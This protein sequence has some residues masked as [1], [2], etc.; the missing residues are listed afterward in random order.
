MNK[1]IL[2]VLA[3]GFL[4]AVLVALMVQMSLSGNKKQ[5]VAAAKPEAKAMIVVAAKDLKSGD[6]LDAQNMKWQEWP[7][8]GVFPGAYVQ[9]KKDQSVTD[10][11]T[12]RAKGD[13]PTGEPVVRSSVI[14]EGS[15]LMAANLREGMRA[16]SIDMKPASSVSGFVAPGDYVDILLTYST[17]IKYQGEN[18]VVRNMLD[19]NFSKTATE[20]IIENVKVLAVDQ[21]MK[22]EEEQKMVVP[23]T[24]TV[25]VTPR[26]AETLALAR[27]I[28]DVSLALRRLGD[29]TVA[30]GYTPA[31][32]DSRITSIWDEIYATM[33]RM[34]TDNAGQGANIVRVYNGATTNNVSV[35][36]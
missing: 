24:V 2:I 6:K 35:Q 28:G 18:P 4:I 27:K 17:R 9:E 32:T 11:V 14:K 31:T 30:E 8:S 12:G 36:P 13:I 19:A 26:G 15:T 33:E 5:Q 7:K 22:T 29:K 21:R 16:V 25:E 20:I 1:N 10:V 3:G 34:T 23:K